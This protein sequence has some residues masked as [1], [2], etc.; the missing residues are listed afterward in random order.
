MGKARVLVTV[1]V[2][3][4]LEMMDL[5]NSEAFKTLA[6]QAVSSVAAQVIGANV[7]PQWADVGYYVTT[8][9]HRSSRDS[10]CDECYNAANDRIK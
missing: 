8:H 5:L 1:D 4:D 3:D 6:G 7:N 10:Y 2:P 9:L